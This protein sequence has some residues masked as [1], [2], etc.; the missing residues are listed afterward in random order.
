[1]IILL[2][3][4]VASGCSDTEQLGPPA[5][6]LD[7]PDV[8]RYT[9]DPNTILAKLNQGN[10]SR[11]LFQPLPEGSDN[12]VRSTDSLGWQPSDYIRVANALNLVAKQD[13]LGE[14][15][16][17]KLL[18]TGYCD[19][20]PVGFEDADITYFK[21]N[22][23]NYYTRRVGIYL[24][25]KEADWAG[26]AVSPRPYFGWKNVDL[27]KFKIS[28]DDAFQIAEAN[29]GK[30]IRQAVNNLCHFN[31]VIS[32]NGDFGNWQVQYYGGP[33]DATLFMININPD[34]GTYE[35]ITH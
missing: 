19:T 25:G 16:I 11:E 35:I 7:Y 28:A 1:M 8:H 21:T 31:M 4:L 29:G 14:W 32:P 13:D 24:W 5:Y 20:N 30:A 18:F 2:L 22:G 26:G 15:S 33:S 10:D 3:L 23:E 12:S 27:K 17:Y 34:D 6:I 9:F